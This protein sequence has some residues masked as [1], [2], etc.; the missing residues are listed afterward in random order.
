MPIANFMPIAHIGGYFFKKFTGSLLQDPAGIGQEA[1]VSG[2][3]RVYRRDIFIT[4][5]PHLSMRPLV[6]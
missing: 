6:Y 5:Q 1:C 4:K 3:R 2:D